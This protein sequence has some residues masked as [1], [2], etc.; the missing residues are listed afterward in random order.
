MFGAKA[1]SLRI[2]DR[3]RSKL[4]MDWC[5]PSCSRGG[6]AR[7]RLAESTSEGGRCNDSLNGL[8]GR[9]IRSSGSQH[10][11]RG[12]HVIAMV[13]DLKRLNTK[14]ETKD[15]DDAKER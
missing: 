9:W 4:L 1:L 8:L 5:G 10:E 2:N 13:S 3:G 7:R 14:G 6:K 11:S 15:G 12:I